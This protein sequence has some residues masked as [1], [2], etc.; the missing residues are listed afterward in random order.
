MVVNDGVIEYLGD[1]PHERIPELEVANNSRVIDLKGRTVFPSFIDGHTHL[2]QFGAS[3]LKFDVNRCRNLDEIRTTIA[4]AARSAPEINRLLF[5]GWRQSTTDRLALASMIDDIDPRPIFVDSHDLHSTWC[6]TAALKEMGID[7]NTPD[8]V[9]GSISRNEKGD[10][11]GLVNE[12]AVITLVW[13]HLIGAASREDKLDWIRTAMKSYRASGYT[14][15][16][17]MAMDEGVWELLESLREMSQLD[18]WIAAHWIM[19]PTENDEENLA[20]VQQ[21]ANMRAKYNL[22]NSPDFRIAGIKIICDGVVDSCTAALSKPYLVPP[23]ST[24]GL[25]WTSSALRKVVAKADSEGLQIAMHAIGDAATNQAINVLENLETTG[26]RH[27]IE[28]LELTRPEDAER[29]GRLGITASIQPVHSDP[30]GLEAWPALIGTERC[31]WAFTHKRF[32]DSGAQIAIGTD[33]PTA[34]HQPFPNLYVANTRSSVRDPSNHWKI[35]G[36]EPLSLHQCFSAASWGSAFSCFAESITGSLEVGKRADFIVVDGL[37]ED[38][39]AQT[40]LLAS[41]A[42]TWMCGQLVFQRQ[43]NSEGVFD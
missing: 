40:L 27:R 42:Q 3:I 30:S 14:G 17:E 19:F 28:H 8:P 21:A 10:P 33:A 32:H 9:G 23:H 35:N 12:G 26:R 29:L 37:S 20:Q 13:P 43:A 2:L 6:N 39:S 22:D 36:C 11:T 38:L 16:I 18:L 4:E 1:I 34:P 5:R 7:R 25:N 31:D 15:I 41:V 24:G